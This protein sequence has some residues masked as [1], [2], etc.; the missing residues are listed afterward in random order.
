MRKAASKTGKAA[1]CLQLAAFIL[2]ARLGGFE[3][4]AVC[5]EGRC[6]IRLSY[7]RAWY[8]QGVGPCSPTGGSVFYTRTA[9]GVKP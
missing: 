6:S 2:M 4:P 7:R 8:M 3:P 9:D 1:S 5:L